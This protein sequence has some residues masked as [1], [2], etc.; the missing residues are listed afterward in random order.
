MVTDQHAGD[1]KDG[2]EDK[3]H[4]SID[5]FGGSGSIVSIGSLSGGNGGGIPAGEPVFVDHLP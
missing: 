2:F 4:T 1:L 3:V 5:G